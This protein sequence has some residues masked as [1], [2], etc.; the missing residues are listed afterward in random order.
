MTVDLRRARARAIVRDGHPIGPRMHPCACGAPRHAHT[1]RNWSGS[2][3]P[4]GCRRYR[5]DVADILAERAMNA[6]HTDILQDVVAWHSAVYPRPTPTPGGWGVG[7]SDTS[8]CRKAIQLR[9]RP[10]D[11]IVYNPVDESAAVLGSIFHDVIHRARAHLYPWRKYEF[12][13]TVPGLDRP[14][15]VDEYD[16]IAAIT[17]DYKTASEYLW[18][19]IGVDGPI[20]EH[21]EQLAIYCYALV[22]AGYDVDVMCLIYIRRSTGE[23]EYH[24]RPYDDAYAKAAVAKLTSIMLMLDMDEDL[25]RDGRGPSSDPICAKFCNVRDYCWNVAAATAAGRTPESYTLLGE[26]PEVAAIEWAA[27]QARDWGDNK[28]EAKKE[29]DAAIPL[30][31]GV[32]DGEYGQYVITEKKRR[33]PDYK[34][35]YESVRREYETYRLLPEPERG[36]FADW[37]A[38]IPLPRRLDVWT[39]VKRKRRTTR[40][41]VI[42]EKE[43][44]S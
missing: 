1:G 15:R 18:E 33:M 29:Y 17:T 13:V 27:S 2:H 28:A 20:E 22:C 11:D 5:R 24:E 30:L 7:P 26:H 12:A 25:P 14:G 23:C 36:D 10:P 39:E 44:V 37:V 6:T 38:R 42:K 41:P 43:A 21:W 16:P 34:A 4:T 3:N 19:T 31:G 9:E 40:K 35:F 32:P 8:S